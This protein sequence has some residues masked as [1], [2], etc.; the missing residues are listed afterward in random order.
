VESYPVPIHVTK[1][2][3]IELRDRMRTRRRWDG[4]S[5]GQSPGRPLV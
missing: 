3:C 4:G 1:A 2:V 5:D